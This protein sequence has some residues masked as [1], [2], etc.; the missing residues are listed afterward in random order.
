MQN[1]P[2]D[3]SGEPHIY[4]RHSWVVALSFHDVDH[5]G[6]EDIWLS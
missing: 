6:T 1:W 2:T 3:Q 4:D 5:L